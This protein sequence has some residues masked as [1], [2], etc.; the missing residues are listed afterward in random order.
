M[1]L[2]AFSCNDEELGGELNLDPVNKSIIDYLKSIPD[3]S[4]LLEAIDNVNLMGTLNL[5]GNL[6]MFAP[7]NEGFEKYFAEAGISGLSDIDDVLLKRIVLYHLYS[8]KFNSGV[9]Q[10]GSLP[11]VTVSGDLI[12]MDISQGLRNTY[13]NNTIKIDT[14]DITVTNGVIH[15][16][17]DLLI[18][19]SNTI[20]SGLSENPKYSIITEAIHQTGI[21][22]AVL[23][24]VTYDNTTIINGQPSKNWITV[25][26]E[27]DSIFNL[28]GINSFDDLARKYSNTYNTTKD[29]ANPADS[30]NI[31]IR[32]HCMQRRFFISD[33]SDTYLES[34]SDGNWLIFD[35]KGG[36]NI[37]KHDINIGGNIV[38]YKVEIDLG[39]SNL[40]MSNGIMHSIGS[41]LNVYVPAPIIVRA[42]FGGAPEDRVIKLLDGT[43]TTFKDQLN[44][45]KDDPEG[46]SVVWWLKWGSASGNFS[47]AGNKALNAGLNSVYSWNPLYKTD[48][49]PAEEMDGL[50]AASGNKSVWFE[51][52][53]KPVF[54]GKYTLYL[55]EQQ[56]NVNIV[57]Q[58][59][60]ILWS[61]DGV[62][63][64]DMIDLMQN[65]TDAFGN[66]I[67]LVNEKKF[68]NQ[69]GTNAQNQYVWNNYPYIMKR[70]L[71]VYT[72][73]EI[74]AHKFKVQYVDDTNNRAV[75]QKIQLEPTQ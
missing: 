53:T 26:V 24:K 7:T 51:L 50:Q 38:N 63:A 29:Y 14:L 4:I 45:L 60:K 19:P 42:Y 64:P 12:K 47:I 13:L 62:Q 68:D 6:T 23:N 27:P 20:Y 31:F 70:K 25:F 37:N 36:L 30:L 28:N 16:I 49:M 10:T 72:F 35:T 75:F 65:K 15:V 71:G 40:V 74:K 17:N 69:S 46:Q 61:F 67:R 59:W 39:K 48:P 2:A 11:A 18:P 66:D 54:K 43:V 34:M 5:Y 32:Y 41:V 8:Q 9:F 21:D 56:N 55:Y 22:T 3:Y 52:T 1:T 73:N 44:N 57:V 58:Q 33:F